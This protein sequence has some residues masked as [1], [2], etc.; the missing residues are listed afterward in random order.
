MN[1]IDH[2]EWQ[3]PTEN[4]LFFKT[5]KVKNGAEYI[6]SAFICIDQNDGNPRC[7]PQTK[8]SCPGTIHPDFQYCT[9]KAP[10]K[11]K[12]AFDVP[13]SGRDIPVTPPSPSHYPTE[14]ISQFPTL[15]PEIRITKPIKRPPT[16]K[17]PR[18]LPSPQPLSS[19]EP[20]L[21]VSGNGIVDV[22]DYLIS[23]RNYG[24]SLS[25]DS[26]TNMVINAQFISRILSNLGRGVQ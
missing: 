5:N 2:Q 19:A 12:Y 20:L 9:M 11:V 15:E 4:T 14:Y 13:P 10:G 23:L 16:T 26:T 3:N 25:T 18:P 6:V 24:Q 21:D 17:T 1:E 8:S 22:A 7:I